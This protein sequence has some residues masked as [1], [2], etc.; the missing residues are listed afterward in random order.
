MRCVKLQY[1][2][3]KYRNLATSFAISASPAREATPKSVLYIDPA[4]YFWRKKY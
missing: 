3:S 1:L 4:P 2:L